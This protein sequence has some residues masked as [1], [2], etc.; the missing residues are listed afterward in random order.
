MRI[1][2]METTENLFEYN[3][4]E[5]MLGVL[6]LSSNQSIWPLFSRG[7]LMPPVFEKTDFKTFDDSPFKILCCEKSIPSNWCAEIVTS[8]RN[9]Y[10]IAILLNRDS[11]IRTSLLEEGPIEQVFLTISS[12][13]SLYFRSEREMH[14]FKSRSFDDMNLNY[15]GINYTANNAIFNGKF[16]DVPSESIP[17]PEE[18]IDYNN[19][20]KRA[21][22]VSAI[23]TCYEKSSSNSYGFI[24]NFCDLLNLDIG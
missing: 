12:V 23:I 4:P 20:L 5:N 2:T 8:Q 22:S 6:A 1:K 9:A 21:D 7:C 10:P 24:N 19:I 3:E 11:R 13:H 16:K 18:G 14:Q 17:P 15:S